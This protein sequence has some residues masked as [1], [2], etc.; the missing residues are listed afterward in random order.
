MNWCRIAAKK[1]YRTSIS[2]H[3]CRLLLTPTS[4]KQADECR[5]HC[6]DDGSRAVKAGHITGLNQTSAAAV[7]NTLILRLIIRRRAVRRCGDRQG[8]NALAFK[9]VVGLLGGSRPL[10]G[11]R[12]VAC[13]HIGLAAG[14]L[15][16][17]GFAVDEAVDPA[18]RRKG[19]AVIRPGCRLGGHRI[20]SGR[21]DDVRRGFQGLGLILD[22][23]VNLYLNRIR[24]CIFVLGCDIAPRF[25]AIGAVLNCALL[26]EVLSLVLILLSKIASLVDGDIDRRKAMLF[27]VISVFIADYVKACPQRVKGVSLSTVVNISNGVAGFPDGGMLISTFLV[28]PTNKRLARGS[29]FALGYLDGVTL[30]KTIVV[31]PLLLAIGNSVCGG[32]SM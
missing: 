15:Q 4:S 11:V 20:R 27:A 9:L 19:G 3:R 25:T 28:K 32:Q 2:I 17:G 22:G 12:V 6:R 13:A 5:N 30:C 10:D 26:D 14:Y 31:V 23:H 7:E 21:D 1:R 29:G 24:T 16:V 8:S 18:S